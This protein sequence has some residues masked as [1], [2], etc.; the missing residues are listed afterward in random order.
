MK[1]IKTIIKILLVFTIILSAFPAATVLAKEDSTASGYR[2]ISY[3]ISSSDLENYAEGGRS[4]LDI[5]LRSKLPSGVVYTLDS[6][7]RYIILTLRFDFSSLD[8]YRQKVLRLC[9]SEVALL[10]SQSPEIVIVE[11][12]SPADYLNCLIETN[13][14]SDLNG[15]E[16]NSQNQDD[17][18]NII[19]LKKLV[20]VT[21]NLLYIDGKEHSIDGSVNIYPEANKDEEN[22]DNDETIKAD[23]IYITTKA[24]RDGS[25]ER[26]VTVGLYDDE[27]GSKKKHFNRTMKAA[28]T[29]KKNEISD[30]E[31]ALEVTLESND[32]KE[33]SSLTGLCL[34]CTVLSEETL[35]PLD[36]GNFNVLSQEYFGISSLLHDQSEFIYTFDTPTSYKN[37]KAINGS[38]YIE[39][40]NIC[41]GKQLVTFNY[42]QKFSFSSIKVYT[43]LSGLLG[44]IERTITLSVSND[45]AY[46]YHNVIKTTLSDRLIDNSVMTISEDDQNTNYEIVYSSFSVDKISEFTD[47]ILNSSGKL[48]VERE[49]LGLNNKVS[50]T[51]SVTDILPKMSKSQSAVFEYKLISTASAKGSSGEEDVIITIEGTNAIWEVASNSEMS[52]RYQGINILH[53]I[54]I[55]VVITILLLVFLIVHKK[56]FRK[57]KI[58][59]P[60]EIGQN[61]P[62][63]TATSNES[64]S[65][66]ESQ[67]TPEKTQTIN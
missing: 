17:E 36:E 6:F 21:Q 65:K 19:T 5:A 43:D 10:C 54:L 8:D 55:A 48:K 23:Y 14:A 28:G 12:A 52:F 11:S 59:T 16:N 32:K 53:A 2:S 50:E 20:T 58:N 18:S 57:P 56:Q 30:Y 42:E 27:D 38:S 24:K 46:Y 9:G 37:I 41:S 31:L 3:Q 51:V 47:A 44:R 63:S 40:D 45:V 29:V 35:S 1:K 22:T 61:S 13:E 26:K 7:E 4:G 62:Q 39:N 64:M 33:L 67:N 49:F 34:G 15:D 66:D 25:F 60:T